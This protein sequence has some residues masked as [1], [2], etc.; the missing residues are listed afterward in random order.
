MQGET[1]W[2]ASPVAVMKTSV[3]LDVLASSLLAGE[4]NV[5]DAHSRLV[6]SLGRNWRWLRPLA[7]RYVKAFGRRTRP[8]RREVLAFLRKDSGLLEARRR[9]REE[10]EIK[11]WLAEPQIMQPI[12]VASTWNVPAIESVG[13]LSEWLAVNPSELLWLADLKGLAAKMK[14][15]R[16]QHYHYRV[17]RKSTGGFRLIEIPKPRLK[18]IQRQILFHILNKISAASRRTRVSAG[19]FRF[20]RLSLRMWAVASFSAWI[21][22]ISSRP[23]VPHASQHSFVSPGIRNRSPTCSPDSVRPPHRARY[24]LTWRRAASTMPHTRAATC[25]RGLICLKAP[26]HPRRSQTSAPTAPIAAWPAWRNRPVRNTRVTPTIWRFP[27]TKIS[28]N[29]WIASRSTW[30]QF[31]LRKDFQ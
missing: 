6:R 23:P 19:P 1:R 10:I 31:W 17:L 25:I 11:H 21:C 28:R 30:L 27:A 29:V 12:T 8:H 9:Y 16:L 5:A 18:D 22:R 26:R 24:G 20:E 7:A 14:A 3:L 4:A 15:P 2:S 13:A